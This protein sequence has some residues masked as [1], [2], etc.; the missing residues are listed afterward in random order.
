MIAAFCTTAAY[1]PQAIKILRTRHTKD[2]S[3]G[4]YVLMTAGVGSWLIFGIM[5]ESPSMMVANSITLMLSAVIL[6]MKI[7]YG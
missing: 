3:L 6:I 5:L 1:V 4:M 2:I 7:R